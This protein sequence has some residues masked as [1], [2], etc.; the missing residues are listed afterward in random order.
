MGRGLLFVHKFTWSI[1][2]F[3]AVLV[4]LFQFHG[5]FGT[6]YYYH[7]FL[8]DQIFK[9]GQLHPA[10]H[11]LLQQPTY[12]N[13][14]W[15]FQCVIRAAY[16]VHEVWGP[17]LVFVALWLAIGALFLRLLNANQRPLLAFPF[18]LSALVAAQLRMEYRPEVVSMLLLVST[19]LMLTR[20][21]FTRPL[22]KG[23]WVLV[24][25]IP[26]IWSN[27][28]GYFIFGIALG[29]W[30]L[31][32]SYLL[33]ESKQTKK[34][35]L[36]FVIV[37]L[38]ATCAGPLVL[39]PWQNAWNQIGFFGVMKN[40][41]QEFMGSTHPIY[42][43]LWSMKLFFGWWIVTMIVTL[44]GAIKYKHLMFQLGSAGL[45][46]GLGYLGYRNVPLFFVLS[47]PLWSEMLS[48]LQAYLKSGSRQVE[49]EKIT[50]RTVVFVNALMVGLIGSVVSSKYY[51]WRYSESELSLGPSPI[52]FPVA[53]SKFI[54]EKKFAGKIF[55]TPST[56]GFLELFSPDVTLYGDSRF[57]DPEPVKRYFRA[58]TEIEAFQSLDRSHQFDGVLT[59]ILTNQ[60]LVYGLFKNPDWVFV[61]GDLNFVFFVHRASKWRS[62]FE[63]PHFDAYQGQDLFRGDIGNRIYQW[64]LFLKD[65]QRGVELQILKNQLTAAKVLPKKIANAV[66]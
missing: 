34:R 55:N 39:K 41:I 17:H 27:S 1:W 66:N 36:L 18:V 42:M 44:L 31:T 65:R 29:V 24:F 8:G 22:S 12:I 45:G 62:N 3:L 57:M 64:I 43:R 9:T 25:L 30:R 63:I 4:V 5:L 16:G 28:H 49:E 2:V 23:N 7:L 21:D 59:S 37:S 19:L 51:D 50:L 14:Y 38:V 20:I 47:A 61:Y 15:L 11:L 35:L 32:T 10:D 33:G 52:S 40:Q 13:I 53:F 56:G 58:D 60:K 26:W 54:N 48:K 46:L 6:D